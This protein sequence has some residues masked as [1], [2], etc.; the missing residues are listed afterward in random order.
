MITINV[1][2]MTII[3]EAVGYRIGLIFNV[4]DAVIERLPIMIYVLGPLIITDQIQGVIAGIIRGAG[5]QS[6]GAIINFIS[7]YI[8]G[9]PIGISLTFGVHLRALGMWIG[10]LCASSSQLTGYSI[11][12][13]SFKWKKESDLAIKRASSNTR[14]S[15]INLKDDNSSSAEVIELQSYTPLSQDE[16]DN[17]HEDDDGIDGDDVMMDDDDSDNDSSPIITSDV[18]N[19]E[20]SKQQVIRMISSHHIKL[21]LLRG[22][23]YVI[24][25]VG[26][27]G[28]GIAS[29]YQPPESIINGN[30]TDCTDGY[31]NDLG[32]ISVAS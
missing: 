12:V 26:C 1:L 23:L 4:E 9:L 5:H 22:S 18:S 27:I 29:Q 24:G 28:A 16:A 21:L 15:D 14:N 8:I 20:Q 11:L 10:L 2:L 30:Y 19:S 3:I 25:V 32:N 7:Y 17:Q 13:A 31:N 6:H